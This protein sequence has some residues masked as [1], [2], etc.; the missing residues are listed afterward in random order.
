MKKSTESHLHTG[1][2]KE[3]CVKWGNDLVHFDRVGEGVSSDDFI[4]STKGDVFS[5]E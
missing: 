4:H 1:R 3:N 5:A 2:R